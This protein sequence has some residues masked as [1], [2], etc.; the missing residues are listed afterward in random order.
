M[1]IFGCICRFLD[2]LRDGI[3]GLDNLNIVQWLFS[4]NYAPRPG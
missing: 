3:S 2:A 4:E 1:T